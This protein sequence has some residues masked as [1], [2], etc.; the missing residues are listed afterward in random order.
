MKVK[1]KIEIVQ[2]IC[3]L[4]TIGR[5]RYAHHS[6]KCCGADICDE[7]ANAICVTRLSDYRRHE[8][9]WCDKCVKRL[10]VRR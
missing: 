10:K 2:R 1:K 3:D 6:C 4:C 9:V 7:H 5:R 8:S